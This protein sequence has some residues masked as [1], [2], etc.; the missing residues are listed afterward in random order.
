[1]NDI[2]PFAATCLDPDCI[3]VREKSQTHVQPKN[4]WMTASKKKQAHKYREQ[5]SGY[6]WCGRSKRGVGN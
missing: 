6:Q 3:T 1:M 4:K 5:T 2:L